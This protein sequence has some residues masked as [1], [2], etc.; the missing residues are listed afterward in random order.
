VEGIFDVPLVSLLLHSL[1]SSFAGYTPALSQIAY[2]TSLQALSRNMDITQ[3]GL[4]EKLVFLLS[5]IPE[6]FK[7]NPIIFSTLCQIGH[8]LSSIPATVEGV[9]SEDGAKWLSQHFISLLS[10]TMKEEN[11]KMQVERSMIEL[12]SMEGMKRHFHFIFLILTFTPASFVSRI[13][14]LIFNLIETHLA[15]NG[16][17]CVA[18]LATMAKLAQN[19]PFLPSWS[20]FLSSIAHTL[21]SQSFMRSLLL[22]ILEPIHFDA[23]QGLKEVN[24]SISTF[25]ALAASS[26][27]LP[28]LNSHQVDTNELEDAIVRHQKRFEGENSAI[29]SFSLISSFLSPTLPSLKHM[30]VRS[31]VAI[32][33]NL[34]KFD[35][36]HKA[37]F[38][39]DG[40]TWKWLSSNFESSRWQALL[41][42]LSNIDLVDFVKEASD[43]VSECIET[44][45]ERIG[46]VCIEDF[47]FSM[48]V[49]KIM[50]SL[51]SDE[52]VNVDENQLN[53]WIE[54]MERVM[55]QE[56]TFLSK[57]VYH[58][59]AAILSPSLLSSIKYSHPINNFI[60]KV[61]SWS[62]STVGI[63]NWMIRL[64]ELSLS[65]S[66]P[67]HTSETR[68][69]GMVQE[70]FSLAT[71]GPVRA[72]NIQAP[73]NVDL[74]Q[75]GFT[76]PPSHHSRSSSNHISKSDKHSNS[77]K[78]SKSAFSGYSPSIDSSDVDVL[79]SKSSA[80][81]ITIDPSALHGVNME[82][83]YL[84]DGMIRFST[85]SLISS[86]LN[87]PS[88]S[89]K[90]IHYMFGLDEKE[91]N[92]ERGEAEEQ[93]RRNE[94]ETQI[95]AVFLDRCPGFVAQKIRKDTYGHHLEY[96]KYQMLPWLCMTCDYEILF[97]IL[98]PLLS[99]DHL[100]S[101]LELINISSSIV[102]LRI[103]R[104]GDEKSQEKL[105]TN[106]LKSLSSLLASTESH[107]NEDA[108]FSWITLTGF[109]LMNV[110][111]EKHRSLEK[112][113][114]QVFL[115]LLPWISFNTLY[116]RRTAQD[117]VLGILN[118]QYE[119]YKSLSV[120]FVGWLETIKMFTSSLHSTKSLAKPN[121]RES[122]YSDFMASY[123]AGES[124]GWAEKEKRIDLLKFIFSDHPA[125][126]DLSPS[127]IHKREIL[128]SEF[129]RMAG[130][131]MTEG[132]NDLKETFKTI[133]KGGKGGKEGKGE[134]DIEI[135]VE[136]SEIDEE[137]DEGRKDGENNDSHDDSKG[138]LSSLPSL[139]SLSSSLG[140]QMMFQ[141]KIVPWQS[142]S[143]SNDFPSLLS[144]WWSSS[145]SGSL[146]SSS[147]YNKPSKKKNAGQKKGSNSNDGNHL[148]KKT[149][150]KS[151][152]PNNHLSQHQSSSN[153]I[154]NEA[155]SS[156]SSSSAPPSSQHSRQEIVIVASLLKKI[157]NLG[158]LTRTAEIFGASSLVLPSLSVIHDKT[159][160]DVAVS[161]EQWLPLEE[162][163][164]SELEG[165]LRR[166]KEEEGFALI[167][168]EQTSSSLPLH[169]FPFP[170]KSILLL[171]DE[172]HGI[173]VHLLQ[174][175]DHCLEIPQ[176]GI[177][178]SLNVHVS[179]SI[180]IWEYTKQHI[181][182]N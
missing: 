158:G 104:S 34:L 31:M 121:R 133:Q 41:A 37:S 101:I 76:R 91:E 46:S 15:S 47:P 56:K 115:L 182:P 169:L 160:Q 26:T 108:L 64:I 123:L 102:I 25:E 58:F 157:P 171:G 181:S 98:W 97:S 30:N 112:E 87:Y 4:P 162:V 148:S 36:P 40:P 114:K 154:R 29:E 17:T 119:L 81:G 94:I 129:W 107:A 79:E 22:P 39:L 95:P 73:N 125:Q 75:S 55:V 180:C 175:L 153:P 130:E 35:W 127:E 14:S 113:W 19:P 138:S 135:D 44:M 103:L 117:T 166:R 38:E 167:G 105:M 28:I 13:F 52:R 21:S 71:F 161:A 61:L 3:P 2:Q 7:S 100:S 131:L 147:S 27:L 156:S 90:M 60:D 140:S 84:R 33:K 176:L 83:E 72:P 54:R 134:G 66:N 174:C 139:P 1:Q 143:F 68:L 16:P 18:A 6:Y 53:E 165:Y 82:D 96:R 110:S 5:S 111:L 80:Q 12:T 144:S 124:E 49:L 178:R 136:Q 63:G 20:S 8:I 45:V 9:K 177:I 126:H 32:I 23:A 93:E 179:A 106:L 65:P 88:F 86:F 150:D 92:R 89:T 11:Q 78:V 137:R 170:S 146:P 163:G 57:Q 118:K 149:S 128:E 43:E 59:M 159:F 74:L 99:S 155:S 172:K 50:L 168:L 69:N 77:N 122:F 10:E 142:I 85:V 51:L 70:I 145:S 173:P 164:E 67:N 120:E 42:I 132:G 116:I 141:R 62:N 151:V 24:K 152:I 109:T 48:K